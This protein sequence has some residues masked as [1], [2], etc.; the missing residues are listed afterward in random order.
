MKIHVFGHKQVPSR[1]GGVDVVVTEL[2]TR[3]AALGHEVV[4][5]NRTGP[6]CGAYGGV[7]LKKVPAWHR[8]GL[9]A[10]TSS[11]F[12]AVASSFSSTQVCHIHGEGPA[13]MCFLPKLFGKRVVVT[14]HGLDWQREKWKGGLGAAYIRMGE[15]MAVRFANEIIVLSEDTRDYFQTRYKRD[16]HYIPNG[17]TRPAFRKAWEIHNRFGLNKDGF[18]LFLGRLVPEKG[19]DDLIAAFRKVKTSKILVI[20][21]ASSDTDDYVA[22]LQAMAAGDGRIL[23]TGFVEGKLLEELL[24]NAWLYVLPSYLE[25]MPMS[26]LEAISYGNCCLLSDISA[27]RETARDRA[28]YFPAGDREALAE[29]LQKLCDDEIRVQGLQR[30]TSEYVCSK[31][32]WNEITKRTLELYQ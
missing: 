25:G 16:T 10:V 9:A 21:G 6:R 8:R 20:A 19:V 17:I 27:C 7:L 32:D 30:G 31:Y 28:V 15:K 26:L 4:C 29:C 12:A 23:F 22:A 24:S 14:V 13:L 18:L 1:A 5:Y 3:M 11:F 2:S